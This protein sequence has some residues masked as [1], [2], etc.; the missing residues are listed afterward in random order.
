MQFLG[1]ERK[2]IAEQSS[3]AAH[4]LIVDEGPGRSGSTFL[5]TA[6]ALCREGIESRRVTIIGSREFD[7]DSLCAQGAAARWRKFRFLAATSSMSER[8]N[9]WSYLGGGEWRRYFCDG[10]QNWPESWT[11][12]ERFKVLSPDRHELVKFEGMGRI[13]EEARHRA[14]VL[15]GAGFSPRVHDAGE[16]F[17]SYAT[18]PG[19]HLRKSDCS[20]AVLE[21]IARYCAFRSVEFHSPVA[22]DLEPMVTFNVQQEFGQELRLNGALSAAQ[23]VIADGRMQP[24]EWMTGVDGRLVKTDA[25][26]H[27]DNHFFRARVILRGIWRVQPWSGNLIQAQLSFF[28]RNSGNYQG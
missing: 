18:V 17:L 7:P 19:K 5:S 12:M 25:I 15:A 6:E 27:G 13:G 28:S 11:Q 22:S 10:E 16:G 20:V 1:S 2:W 24:Y 8:F 3:R 21:Q 23:A 4:F 9:S 14:F 26:S